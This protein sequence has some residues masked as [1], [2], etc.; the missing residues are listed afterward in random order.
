MIVDALRSRFLIENTKTIQLFLGFVMLFASSQ[1]CIPIQ[2]VPI[3]MQTVGVMLVGLT[4]PY[5]AAMLSVGSYVVLGL[6][7]VPV[8][9]EWASGLGVLLRPSGGYIVGFAL[10]IHVMATLRSRF[11]FTGWNLL[12]ICII[13]QICI[14]ACGIAWLAYHLNSFA[15]ALQ[16][17][18][19][20]FIL[21]GIVKAF[22]L[23]IAVR[24]LLRA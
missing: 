4:L 21:P 22:V 20:P 13:G 23:S 11:A 24:Q 8:F 19:Y 2:P 12:A 17:G 7:G 3:T 18:L 1:I 10:A 15:T 5:R 9:A 14:Y 16:F 6:A